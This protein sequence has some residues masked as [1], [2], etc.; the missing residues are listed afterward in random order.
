MNKKFKPGDLV[1][2]EDDKVTF[3]QLHKGKIY[4]VKSTPHPNSVVIKGSETYW[5]IGR[6]TLFSR[7]ELGKAL[8]S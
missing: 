1:K 6:F 5:R 3:G 8:F 7:T 4:A 2:C